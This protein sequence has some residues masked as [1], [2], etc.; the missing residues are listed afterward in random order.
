METVNKKGLVQYHLDAFGDRPH[1]IIE[2]RP[3]GRTRVYSQPDREKSETQQHFKDEVDL[4]NIMKGYGNSIS[5]VPHSWEGTY[6][7]IANIGDY[8]EALD[9]VAEAERGFMELPSSIRERFGNDPQ[10]LFDFMQD[11]S[12]R[13]EAYKIGLLQ[14]P[15]ENENDKTINN[16]AEAIVKAQEKIAS[17]QKKQAGESGS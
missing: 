11:E 7:D 3:N 4:N 6:A 14:R 16:T 9:F 1:Q 10:Y 5:A 12:N 2:K 15:A 13:E 17:K 8:R